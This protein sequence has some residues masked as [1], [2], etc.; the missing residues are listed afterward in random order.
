MSRTCRPSLTTTFSWDW[1]WKR[2]KNTRAW[3]IPAHPVVHVSAAQSNRTLQTCLLSKNAERRSGPPPRRQPKPRGN[4]SQAFGHSNA[5]R[6]ARR[7]E[8]RFGMVAAPLRRSPIPQTV[9]GL[10]RDWGGGVRLF[11]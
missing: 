3:V 11:L 4:E 2:T 7:T 10:V 5:L 8:T 6:W 1:G 9:E